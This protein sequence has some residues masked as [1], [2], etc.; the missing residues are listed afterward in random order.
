M[1]DPTE[2]KR[3]LADASWRAMFEFFVRTAPQ[4]D[5]Q[6]ERVGLT[7]NDAKVLRTLDARVG[8]PMSTLAKQWGTD[9]SNATWA[10][11]RLEGRGLV[12]RRTSP[13]DGR[14]KL[15]FLTSKGTR[16]I[17]SLTR[18]LQQ[19]PPALLALGEDDLAKLGEIFEKLGSGA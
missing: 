11:G 2:R 5:R 8:V 6:L 12:E 18:A 10:I 7:P 16:A 9:A 3:Q 4:R 14:V 1:A 15:V 13:E 17:A 19:P